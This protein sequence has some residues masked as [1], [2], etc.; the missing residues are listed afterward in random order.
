MEVVKDMAIMAKDMEAMTIMDH[1]AV[2]VEVGITMEDMEAMM[3]QDMVVVPAMAA[4]RT[5]Q[6]MVNTATTVTT[7]HKNIIIKIS[8]IKSVLL[9]LN[10]YIKRTPQTNKH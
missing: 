2:M 8:N 9:C 10:N 6:I 5:F 4:I 1:K 7:I 3:H